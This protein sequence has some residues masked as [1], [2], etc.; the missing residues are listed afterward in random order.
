MPTYSFHLYRTLSGDYS[1][2]IKLFGLQAGDTVSVKAVTINSIDFDKLPLGFGEGMSVAAFTQWHTTPVLP[3]YLTAGF[4]FGAFTGLN[5]LI[6]QAPRFWT[7]LEN[8]EATRSYSANGT[9]THTDN[10]P[11]NFTG[12][13]GGS[14]SL[15]LSLYAPW[16]AA[17]N[18]TPDFV[19]VTVSLTTNRPK[20][21][22]PTQ[23]TQ[24]Q[25]AKFL[26]DAAT[27][28]KLT[29]GMTSLGSA[30]DPTSAPLNGL[31]WLIDQAGQAINPQMGTASATAKTMPE[32]LL[33]AGILSENLPA[34][35]PV[36]FTVGLASIFTTRASDILRVLAND[37]PDLNYGQVL[38]FPHEVFAPIDGVG[39]TG[40][41]LL[42]ALY[43]M[44]GDLTEMLAAAE[45]FQGADFADATAAKAAQEAAFDAALSA[46]NARRVAVADALAAFLAESV[47]TD[48]NFED[49]T[50]TSL[51]ATFFQ[52]LGSLTEDPILNEFVTGLIDSFFPSSQPAQFLQ[53]IQDALEDPGLAAQMSAF[54]PFLLLGDF[55][56]EIEDAIANAPVSPFTGSVLDGLDDVIAALSTE[57]PPPPPVGP[58]VTLTGNGVDIA[59]G[60]ASPS[61][62][63][64]TAFGTHEVKAVVQRTFTV[65][66][67]GTADLTTTGLLLPA[68]F[69]IGTDKLL[70][71]LT[72]GQS[73]TFSVLLDTK[74]LGTFGGSITF[75]T[76]DANEPAFDFAVSASVVAPREIDVLGNGISIKDG[77]KKALV[78]NDTDFGPGIG[79]DDA[80][81]VRTFTVTNTG[82]AALT[83]ASANLVGLGFTLL[84]DLTGTVLQD[85]QSITFDVEMD[86]SI[87]GTR[88]AT[89]QINSNDAN[90]ALYDFV[91][92]GKVGPRKILGDDGDPDFFVATA[93][94]EAFNG[95]GNHDFVSYENA[96][97][98]VVAS[99]LSPLKNTGFAAGDTYTSIESLTGS[100]FNDTLTGDAGNNNLVGGLGADKLD[101]G[102]SFDTATYWTATS[103]VTVNMLKIALN[104]GEAAGDTY[105]NIEG[106]TGTDHADSLT[107]DN[108]SNS[109]LGLDGND[110]L[111]GAGGIDEL[112]GHGGFDTFLFNAIK[113]GG[114]ATKVIGVVPPP[115]GDL[116]RDFVSGEDHIGIL[117]S[118]FKIAVDVDVGAGG[119][120]DF[121][122]QYFV[123][124]AGVAPT[125]ANQTGVAATETGHGQF[126]FNET[127]DQLWWDADGT[128]KAAATLLAT[129][130][131]GAHVT[132]TD[133]DLL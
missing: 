32:V 59:D 12:A 116:I 115:T 48:I 82:G 61:D 80:P 57:P 131:S 16:G 11:N 9:F 88:T 122:G 4:S 104:T 100:A 65:T 41:A 44:V 66:N 93:E 120:L 105:K 70:A 22:L 99:L 27:I 110:T 124:A 7:Y 67:T 96:A 10:V 29:D 21:D 14:D 132:A 123:S 52:G 50:S 94:P 43:K 81:P 55:V 19:S 109:I 103:G 2:A 119:A 76:N 74:T 3:D 95:F 68:G 117:R 62:G 113:D 51:A 8:Y 126:L 64:H 125:V 36:A 111:A 91:I 42:E 90:E 37:P 5:H 84:T 106:L 129:F 31:N 112:F 38:D 118:G 40:N 13:Y 130:T 54:A 28:D 127:T 101:G 56:S 128:G 53:A 45:R 6:V 79:L 23:F 46:Y 89:I 1:E 102:A 108:K 87:A 121:A 75:N 98:G 17:Y 71:K 25:K 33:T 20:P 78:T 73:D 133:F 24:E 30:V 63:D 114:G 86:T 107:G 18:L 47:L 72:P 49:T 15:Y 58:E 92:G 39:A 83:I 69:K 97:A 34:V 77:S 85:G 60:D 26:A 35:G